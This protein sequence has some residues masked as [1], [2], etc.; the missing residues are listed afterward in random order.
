[1]AKFYGKVGYAE[2]VAPTEDNPGVWTTQIVERNYY[3]DLI[4]QSRVIDA[5]QNSTIDGINLNHRISILADPYAFNNYALIRYVEYGGV[6]WKVSTIEVQ[7][8]RLVLNFG[9][10]WNG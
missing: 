1:M 10:V 8:P 3:G 5:S 2:S 9:G 4:S 6:K 7:Y